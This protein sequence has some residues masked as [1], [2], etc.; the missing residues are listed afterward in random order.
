MVWAVNPRHSTLESLAR[1]LSRFAADFL[2][3]AGLRVRLDVPFDLPEIDLSPEQRHNLYLACREVLNN[4]VR[5]AQASEVQLRNDVTDQKLTIALV[6]DGRG[7]VPGDAD[8]GEGLENLRR[9]LA[10]N[11]GAC[12]IVSHPGHGTTVTFSIH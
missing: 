12:E 10:E 1:Y 3:P 11:G 6:D 5:H 2:A 9:R 4:V 7:F 8:D